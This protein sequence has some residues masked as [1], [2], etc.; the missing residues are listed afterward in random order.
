MSILVF[1]IGIAFRLVL[2]ALVSYLLTLGLCIA[3]EH[4]FPWPK[5]LC[6][7]NAYLQ[8]LFFFAC[9]VALFEWIAARMRKGRAGYG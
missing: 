8:I 4:G 7:H 9:S 1:L 3:V 6:G 5:N 2:A